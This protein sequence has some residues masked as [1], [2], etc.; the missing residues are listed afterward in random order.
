MIKNRYCPKKLIYLGDNA[1]NRKAI[2][3]SSPREYEP[4]GVE[5]IELGESAF[6]D[7]YKQVAVACGAELIHINDIKMVDKDE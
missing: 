4:I 3:I 5:T 7:E 2:L 6:I 1:E